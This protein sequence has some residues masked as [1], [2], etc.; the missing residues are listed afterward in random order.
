MA[1]TCCLSI[2][3]ELEASGL[4]SRRMEKTYY[5]LAES[6][7][8]RKLRLMLRCTSGI[9]LWIPPTAVEEYLSGQPVHQQRQ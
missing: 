4:H 5:V 3:S 9:T 6:T 7:T 8:G 2:A 1:S